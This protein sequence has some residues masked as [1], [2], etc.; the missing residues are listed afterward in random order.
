MSGA[1]APVIAIVL[2]ALF[3]R[4]LARLVV[5]A[6]MISI[7]VLGVAILAVAAAVAGFGSFLVLVGDF[8]AGVAA[9]AL[10]RARVATARVRAVL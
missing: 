9:K 4:T 7:L 3:A 1:A 6:A 2:L 5:I 8:L 10:K